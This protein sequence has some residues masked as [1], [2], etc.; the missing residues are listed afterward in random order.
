LPP[1]GR[2]LVERHAPPGGR[3]RDLER[4]DELVG[5]ERGRVRPEE[6]LPGGDRAAPSPRRGD[7]A[8]VEGERARRQLRG[9]VGVG[10]AAAEGAAVPDRLVADVRGGAREERGVLGDDRGL[11]E[12]AVQRERAEAQHALL[13]GDA[14]Q[15]LEPP[16]VDE[17]RRPGEAHV[18]DRDEA[19][20]AGDGTRLAG[21]R[22]EQ[23][24]RLVEAGRAQVLERLGLHGDLPRAEGPAARR[25]GDLFIN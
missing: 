1:A 13:H 8:R 16:D 2:E 11:R 18:H 5:L 23:A 20:A 17:R 21:P 4:D 10:E 7:H 22:R 15:D 24:Q 12:L 19:L 9:G 6:E 14:A 3:E 25:R